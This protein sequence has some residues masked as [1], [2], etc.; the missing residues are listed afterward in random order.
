MA[1]PGPAFL[2]LS[3]CQ[4]AQTHVFD[5]EQA[6][7][8]SA[9]LA[10]WLCTAITPN[11]GIRHRFWPPL[12]IRYLRALNIIVAAITSRNQPKPFFS[13]ALSSLTVRRLPICPPT[14]TAT[15]SMSEVRQ[16]Q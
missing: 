16:S 3:P 4:A 1:E 5:P 9:I 14:K 11:N 2:A 8:P 6:D 15:A 12:T 13:L 10:G 7:R